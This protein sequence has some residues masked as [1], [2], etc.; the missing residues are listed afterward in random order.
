M[1]ALIGGMAG[2]VGVEYGL[3]T[4]STAGGSVTVPGEGAS[5]FD[6][7]TVVNLAAEAYAAHGFVNRTGDVG[8]I[9]DGN[10]ATTSITMNGDCSVIANFAERPPM[11]YS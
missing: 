9:G 1:T 5:G 3:S 2:C 8:T 7:G 11:D 10:A 4:T 6:E